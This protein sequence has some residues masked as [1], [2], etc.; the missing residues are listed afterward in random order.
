MKSTS[1]GTVRWRIRSAMNST[2]PFSTP[3]ITQVAALVVAR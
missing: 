3:I 2:A 1:H